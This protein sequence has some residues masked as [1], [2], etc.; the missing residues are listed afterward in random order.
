MSNNRKGCIFCSGFGL[1]KEHI[2]SR[3]TYALVPAAPNSTH[4]RGH[5]VSSRTNRHL[6]DK[7]DVEDY[8]GNLNTI[9]FRVVCKTCNNGWMSRLDN[10]VKPI[11]TPLILRTRA[12]RRP[13]PAPH[14]RVGIHE[15]HGRGTLT[16]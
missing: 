15:G 4:S 9:R 5:A 13:C 16:A 10:A 11:L 8:Q 12:V 2:F 6:F 3:W 7:V 14:H 1:S